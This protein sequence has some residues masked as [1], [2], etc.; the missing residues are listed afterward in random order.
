MK[1]GLEPAVQC[2]LGEDWKEET[3][4]YFHKLEEEERKMCHNTT[5]ERRRK[6]SRR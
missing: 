4:K 3:E 6:R 5:K 2:L 1:T